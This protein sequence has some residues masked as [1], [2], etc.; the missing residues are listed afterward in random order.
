MTDNTVKSASI[1]REAAEMVWQLEAWFNSKKAQI[2]LLAEFDDSDK[3]GLQEPDGK[4]TEVT[5]PKVIKGIKFGA[6]TA[7]ETLGSFPITIQSD[8]EE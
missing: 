5:D 8:E 6:K 4:V 3:L 1:S 2:K 7:L